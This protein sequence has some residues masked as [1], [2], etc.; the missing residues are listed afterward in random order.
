MTVPD[1]SPDD[2]HSPVRELVAACISGER[3]TIEM[4][5]ATGAKPHYFGL[6]FIQLKLDDS[7][8]MHFWHPMLSAVVGEEELHDHRYDFR[9]YVLHGKTTHEVFEFVP[10]ELGGDH[11]MYRVSCKPDDPREPEPAGRGRVV[12]AGSYTMVAGS[13]YEF[14]HDQFHRIEASECITLVFRREIVK[15]LATVIKPLEDGHVCPFS[16]SLP[17]EE[18]WACIGELLED[19]VREPGCGY[20][21]KPIRKGRLGTASK[22]EEEVL[23]FVDALKQDNPVMALVELSD[24]I[25]AIRKWLEANHPTITLEHLVN[26]SDATTRAFVN[27]HRS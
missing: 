13:V 20:H 3:P 15:D 19:R 5:R 8:R 6:G 22:I 18:L 27:G 21:L 17:Q 23:E 4:L 26:M 1:L 9:S 11:G 12:P 24:Q 25:G 16:K 10:D 14:P 2:H 7:W